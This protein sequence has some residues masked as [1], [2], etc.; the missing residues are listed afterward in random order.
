MAT[1]AFTGQ[2]VRTSL[3][4]WFVVGP[5]PAMGVLTVSMEACQSGWESIDVQGMC[6]CDSM[7]NSP[8]RCVGGSRMLPWK[9]SW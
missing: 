5:P 9:L 3:S 1:V 8:V 7:A 6:V 4:W 2:G